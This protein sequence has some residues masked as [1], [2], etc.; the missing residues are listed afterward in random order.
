MRPLHRD[1][2]H[3]FS[4]SWSLFASSRLQKNSRSNATYP[5]HI[6]NPLFLKQQLSAQL[7]VRS[8]VRFAKLCVIWHRSLPSAIGLQR[9]DEARDAVSSIRH[10]SLTICVGAVVAQDADG[11]LLQ[12]GVREEDS[13]GSC[14]VEEQMSNE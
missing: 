14:A 3:S 5:L 1:C 7:T 4:I 10:C 8:I 2:A 11:L 6:V 12:L 9:S 13:A